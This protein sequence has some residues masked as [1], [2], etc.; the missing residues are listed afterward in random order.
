MEINTDVYSFHQGTIKD[1]LEDSITWPVR[2]IIPILPGDY[3]YCSKMKPVH[4]VSMLY[5][6]IVL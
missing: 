5:I 6:Y 4:S 2:K 1:A 3:R